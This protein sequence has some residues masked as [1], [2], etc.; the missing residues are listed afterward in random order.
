[1]TQKTIEDIRA[2][3]DPKGYADDCEAV[4]ASYERNRG[5][6]FVNLDL[7]YD[8]PEMG[9]EERENTIE[10]TERQI[11]QAQWRIER[12]EE[13]IAGMMDG[14]SPSR[15]GRRRAERKA[16]KQGQAAAKKG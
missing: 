5:R 9:D 13:R 16:K 10:E 2:L 8:D 6:L 4:K 7:H 15:S 14:A 1:M 11:R 12:I 3:L